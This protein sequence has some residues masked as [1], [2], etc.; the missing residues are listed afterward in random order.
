MRGA[1]VALT[2]G[3]ILV[4][5]GLKGLSVLEVLAGEKGRTLNP[6]GGAVATGSG[7]ARQGVNTGPVAFKAG[8]G[9]GGS[10][11]IAD[12]L[13]EA[14]QAVSPSLKVISAKRPVVVTASGNVSDHWIGNVVAYAYDLSDGDTPTPGMDRAAVHLAQ[15]IGERYDG[16]SE[17][18]LSKEIEVDGVWYRVQL[19]YRTKVGGNH[20]NHLHAGVKRV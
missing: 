13:K 8:G 10:K 18:V 14:A 9:W 1:F 16:H 7:G 12:Q 19:L 17:L 15:L 11:N 2:I 3:G 6:R 5:S 4:Y 20:F